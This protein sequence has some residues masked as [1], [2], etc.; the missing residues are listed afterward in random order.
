VPRCLELVD[1]AC[2]TAM[3]NE[4]VAID[5]RAGALLIA[6]VDGEGAVCDRDMERLG[7]ILSEAGALDVVVAQDAAQ[8]ERLWATRRELSNVV[9]KLAR[10]K[11]GEDVVVPRGQVAHLVGEVRRIAKRNQVTMLC[12]GHAGDGNLHV[13]TL[14]DDAGELPA[15]R[16]ALDDLFRAVLAVGGTLSGEHGIGTSK[17]EYLSL[18]QS[19]ELIGLQRRLKALFDPRGILNPGK[20]FPRRGTP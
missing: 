18:E 14:W 12:F 2:L 8:R 9:R 3:R 4:G 19:A 1:E 15:V 5:G 16:H 10:H 6:E 7:Q 17:A 20:I 11:I 13:N